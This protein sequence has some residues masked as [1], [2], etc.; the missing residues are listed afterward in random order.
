MG[1]ADYDKDWA[2]SRLFP[3]VMAF[4]I[5]LHVVVITG[6]SKFSAKPELAASPPHSAS[7]P[8]V[9]PP[10]PYR[11]LLLPAHH[12]C[13]PLTS[14]G[15]PLSPWM[16]QRPSFCGIFQPGDRFHMER[17]RMW[18]QTPSLVEYWILNVD[19]PLASY[20]FKKKLLAMLLSPPHGAPCLIPLELEVFSLLSCL[21]SS[22]M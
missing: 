8:V 7:G 17:Q 22:C 18:S 15:S 4:L 10:L 14:Q 1:E 12:L 13:C 6:S 2:H 19:M 3:V 11:L 9:P 5:H 20:L 16:F 21:L